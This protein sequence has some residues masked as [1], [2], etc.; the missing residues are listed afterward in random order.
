[1][2]HVYLQ[3]VAG[4]KIK[5]TGCRSLAAELVRRQV[6]VIAAPTASS[7]L[8]VKAVTTTI[9]IVFLAPE[10]PV[11][12]GLAA[13]LARPGGNLTGVQSFHW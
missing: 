8:A 3:E 11:R 5:R 12:F 1:M 10:D 7:A 9:P 6:N 13:S 2:S 4:P